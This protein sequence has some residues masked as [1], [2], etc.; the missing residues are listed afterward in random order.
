MKNI[1]FNEKTK[2]YFEGWYFKH[3]AGSRM[4]AFIPGINIDNDGF[5]EAFIQIITD[6]GAHCVKYPFEQFDAGLN[7]LYVRIGRNI[8]CDRGVVLDI[9]TDDIFVNGVIAYGEF[10]ELSGSVMGP[11]KNMECNHD[12]ISMHHTLSGKL[13]INGETLNFSGGEGYIEKDWGRSFPQ[14][15]FWAQSYDRSDGTA[16]FVSAAKIPLL[17]G[18]FMGHT[19][20]V[21]HKGKTYRFS[22]FN[23][24]KIEECSGKT[25]RLKKGAY[26]LNVNLAGEGKGKTLFAP[27]SGA[28][29]RKISEMP[30]T[31]MDIS[32]YK[33]G[34]EV[35]SKYAME[36]SAESEF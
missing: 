23:L 12:V 4:A 5:K 36:C 8:F 25:L 6:K 30:G 14:N 11:F 27:V 22:T 10:R 15:Y 32:L 1:H 2:G 24:G 18:S 20:A 16:V 26:T 29:T 19:A 17:G 3:T 7:E 34:R 13:Y 31:S 35:F 28:M 9:D 21:I 33:N